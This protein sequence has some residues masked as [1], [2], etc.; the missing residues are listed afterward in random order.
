MKKWILL[1]LWMAGAV[2]CTPGAITACA[3][4]CEGH[5]GIG[6]ASDK[7]CVC[8]ASLNCIQDAGADR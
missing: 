8:A 7:E 1:V 2:G 4:A 3:N 5:G 6:R